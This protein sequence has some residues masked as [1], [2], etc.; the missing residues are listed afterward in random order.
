MT[1][2]SDELV[3]RL[4]SASSVMALT[5]AGISAESGVPTFRDPGGLWDKFK[6][7]ELANVDAFLENPVLVQTWYGHRRRIIEEVAPNPGHLALAELESLLPEVSVITQNVDGLHQEAG[8]TN[9]AELHGNLRRAYCVD[10]ETPA[11]EDALSPEAENVAMCREC[12]GLIRPDVVWF[13]E[14]LPMDQVRRA[15]NAVQ[16]ADVCLSIGTSAIVYPAAGIPQQARANG[17][18]VAEINVEPSAIADQIDETII[19][20]AGEVL[21]AIVE[22]VRTKQ[23]ATTE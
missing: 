4:V 11:G 13:G 6:P 15:E 9:V 1:T 2:F 18:Y 16:K 17:A 14:M 7:E 10:C 8:S 19:G 3:E 23:S 5:G 12:G 22:A 21:P 20:K